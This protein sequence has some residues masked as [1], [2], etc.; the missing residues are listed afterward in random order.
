MTAVAAHPST[1]LPAVT[2]VNDLTDLV[3]TLNAVAEE[4]QSTHSSLQ[5]QVA[6]LKRELA[7]A[8]AQLRRSQ[9]L[10]A[11]GEM[12][13]GIAH[14]VRNPLGSIQLNVQMLAKDL[15][16]QPAQEALCAK[17]S[18]A[19]EGIDAIVRDVLTFA[20]EMRIRPEPLEA[21]EVFNR[22]LDACES[23][24]RRADIEILRDAE[25]DDAAVFRG[26]SLLLTQALGNVVRN[27][28]EAM[29]E[30][31]P[32]RRMLRLAAGEEL[33]RGP[34]GKR[35]SHIV[36]AVE[37][38]GPGISEEI[39][40]RIFNPFFTTRSTGT[41]L[42]LAMVHRI[43]EAHG[44]H[45]AIGTSPLGGAKVELCLP[46]ERSATPVID[47]DISPVSS[48]SRQSVGSRM[49]VST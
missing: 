25:A 43:A 30:N 33:R 41:G 42:G 6:Q 36:L 13:A 8:N 9:A 14:E 39:R 22:A 11:L 38:S 35:A 37:D 32:R 24:I 17:V 31:A 26:D 21:G 20:R 29:V 18:Q 44:G 47:I 4:L 27:A 5:A 40:D 45:I 28:V 23:L 2:D 10:A 48:E 19:V 49:R 15:C 34:D 16:G 7:E 46:C 12:A 3:R 1:A